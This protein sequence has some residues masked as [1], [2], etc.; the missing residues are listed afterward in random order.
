MKNVVLSDITSLRPQT[1]AIL[2]DVNP[3]SLVAQST[4]A[5]SFSA[6]GITYTHALTFTP[7]GNSILDANPTRT[8]GFT[9]VIDISVRQTQA[10]RP[11]TS[12]AD[13]AAIYL[14]G[15]S[16]RIQIAHP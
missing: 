12:Q 13:D 6:A 7:R 11:P 5:F 2:E 8:S 9:S 3:D 16:G 15:A 10:G 14:Y 1:R 4:S